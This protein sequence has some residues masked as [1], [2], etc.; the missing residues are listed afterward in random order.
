MRGWPRLWPYR[1]RDGRT[2]LL[3]ALAGPTW[4]KF[5]DAVGREDLLKM[6]EQ[7]LDDDTYHRRGSFGT[8]V[9]FPESA[10]CGCPGPR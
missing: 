2:L 4:R 3:E 5:C 7:E 9:M 10:R 8:S 6:H 1:T